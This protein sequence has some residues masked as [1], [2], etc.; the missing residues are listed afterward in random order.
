MKN[1]ECIL[2]VKK[3]EKM[4]EEDHVV[5]VGIIFFRF[6]PHSLKLISAPEWTVMQILTQIKIAKSNNYLVKN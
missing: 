3:L 1:Y 5:Y 2:Q 6:Q 4:M